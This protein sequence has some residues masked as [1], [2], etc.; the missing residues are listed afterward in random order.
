MSDLGTMVTR[1]REDLNRGSD[2]DQRIKKAIVDAIVY[3]SPNR[4][5][6]NVKR[7]RALVTSGME[8]V[9]LPTDWVEAD[10]LRLEDNGRRIPIEEVG[11]DWIEDQ[12]LNDDERGEPEKY[13][14]QHRELRLYP[15]PDH[16]YTLVL[17]FQFKQTEVSLS[18][19]DGA[20]N[21][22]MTEGELLIRYWAQG[23]VLIH[24]IRGE[25][26]IAEGML[27][28]KKAE[29]VILPKLEAQAAREVS[30]GK[31]RGFL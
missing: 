7:S 23:D 13:S 18:A 17:S 26:A 12:Q 3:Y 29:E 28:Q 25:E 15:V 9:S 11:Y 30:A 27:L 10:Y 1:I 31:V 4:L 21:D 8:L 5:G 6:F 20:T 24:H 16:S 22:W 19:S 2:F 14:I